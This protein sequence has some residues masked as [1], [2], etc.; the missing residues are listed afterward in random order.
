[1]SA[2]KFVSGH[3]FEKP[4]T[5]VARQAKLELSADTVSIHKSGIEF[6]SPNPF[7]EWSEM[8]VSLQSP[9]DGSKFSANGVIVACTGTKHAGYHVSMLFTE[10]TPQAAARLGAMARSPFGTS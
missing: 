1:M 5:V 8:T 6:R 7:N 9:V 4:V 3:S 10:L 2:K